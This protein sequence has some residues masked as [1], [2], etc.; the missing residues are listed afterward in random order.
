MREDGTTSAH[1][2]AEV[3][4]DS[5][6]PVFAVPVRLSGR[7]WACTPSSPAGLYQVWHRFRPGWFADHRSVHRRGRSRQEEPMTATTGSAD[8]AVRSGAVLVRPAGYDDAGPLAALDCANRH[9]LAPFEP[10]R[11]EDFFT[12]QGQ[13]HRLAALLD[14]Q[15]EASP[16]P[17]SSRC[18]A[19]WQGGSP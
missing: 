19:G 8:R 6:R 17:M 7:N 1:E 2:H 3:E 18:R 15:A 16:M 5:G 11:D 12:N 4:E 14:Q 10:H 13:A 9:H